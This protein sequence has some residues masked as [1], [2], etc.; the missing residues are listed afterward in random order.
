ME[1]R[2]LI[3]ICGRGGSKGVP[4]KNIKKING[5]HLVGYSIRFAQK[6]KEVFN[7]D[8]ALSTD[9]D[10]IITVAKEYG[11]QTDYR[12]AEDLAGDN[13]GKIPVIKH[14]TEYEEQQRNTKYDFILDLDITSPLRSTED[15][16]EALKVLQNDPEAF[17]IFS[18]SKADKNPYFN[19]VEQGENGYYQLSKSMGDIVSRQQA[20]EVYELNASFY[21]YRRKFFESD[22]KGAITDKSLVYAMSHISF[23]VD[24]PLDFDFL[25]FLI[26]NN[27]LDFKL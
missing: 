24:T 2:I 17:N 5:V 4:G 3:T 23:D 26:T 12:R 20:P 10:E 16:A 8:I 15:V 25:E 6:L 18:V 1:Q 7:A 9:A 21:I 11:L 14:L 22:F 19:M 27:R 13:A